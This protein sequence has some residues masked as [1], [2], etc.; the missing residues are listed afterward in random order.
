M[1]NITFIGILAVELVASASVAWTQTADPIARD[2]ASS[3]GLLC[4][5]KVSCLTQGEHPVFDYDGDGYRDILLAGHGGAPWALMHNDGNDTLS[6]RHSSFSRRTG[7]VASRPMLAVRAVACRTGVPT[8]IASQAPA[9]GSAP[10]LGQTI[11]SCRH[12]STAS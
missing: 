9:R 10:P 8:S 7:M 4:D 1:N 2:I 5:G 6:P 3:A 11:C 12:R